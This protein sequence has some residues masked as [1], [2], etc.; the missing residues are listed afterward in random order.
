MESGGVA[1]NLFISGHDVGVRIRG[2][3]TLRNSIILGGVE[4]GEP[5]NGDQN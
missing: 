1:E 3:G 2:G 4:V 5:P